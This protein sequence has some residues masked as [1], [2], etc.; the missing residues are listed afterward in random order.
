M[1]LEFFGPG[2][3]HF[4]YF[5]A[6]LPFSK[7]DPYKC[8]CCDHTTVYGCVCGCVCGWVGVCAVVFSFGEMYNI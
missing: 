4:S 7:L 8:Y 6:S 5:L 3:I 1:P 2:K